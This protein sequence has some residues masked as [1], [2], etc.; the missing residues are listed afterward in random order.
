MNARAEA[1]SGVFAAKDRLSEACAR[2]Y[3]EHGWILLKGLFDRAR[4]L[5]PIHRVINRLIG[6]KLQHLG[7]GKAPVEPEDTI[8][9]AEF[10]RIAGRDRERAGEIYRACRH[11]LPLHV[12][13]VR[14][15]LIELAAKLMGTRWINYI[16]YTAM[17]IDIPGEEKYL[18]P[19]HQDYPYTQGSV[20]GVIVWSSLFD[21]PL[22]G[23]HLRLIPGSHRR[24]VQKVRLVDPDNRNRNGARTIAIDGAERL[25]AEPFVECPVEAGDALVFHTLLLH[26]STASNAKE[27]RWT[28][29]LRYANFDNADAVLR[30]WPGGMIE[31]AGFEANHPE[32]IAGR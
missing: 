1:G 18:F 7:L 19:W 12:L 6:L 8:Q 10:M 3:S 32:Y 23:G 5:T 29:Q 27:A 17:R 15:E 16:P 25:D 31:G 24:G 30:G 9:Q 20:D 14:T 4:D 28:M 2:H 26:R 13:S 11:L 21:V 22:G